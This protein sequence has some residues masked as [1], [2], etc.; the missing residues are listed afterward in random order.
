MKGVKIMADI[1]L[2]IFIKQF[3]NWLPDQSAKNSVGY[4]WAMGLSLVVILKVFFSLWSDYYVE[5][6]NLVIKNVVRA[7]IINSVCMIPSWAK[8]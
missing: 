5:W 8:K 3:L 1:L 6:C 4:L 2:P 7:K